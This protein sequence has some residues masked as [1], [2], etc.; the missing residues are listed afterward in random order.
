[1]RTIHVRSGHIGRDGCKVRRRDHLPSPGVIPERKP[2]PRFRSPAPLAFPLAMRGFFMR[3]LWRRIKNP[4]FWLGRFS[5][6][7]LLRWPKLWAPASADIPR[8]CRR[9]PLGKGGSQPWDFAVG[10]D[11]MGRPHGVA[12]S[13]GLVGLGAGRV[14]VAGSEDPVVGDRAAGVDRLFRA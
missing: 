14:G 10:P 3:R 8:A 5:R 4:K 9:A 7:R 12:L 2:L 1:S 6:N 11:F 13:G